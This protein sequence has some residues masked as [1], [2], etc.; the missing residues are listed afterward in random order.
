MTEAPLWLQL[1]VLATIVIAAGASFLFAAEFTR[2]RIQENEDRAYLA[3]KQQD[4]MIAAMT[5]N[6]RRQEETYRLI[7]KRR[8]AAEQTVA[9]VL[10]TLPETDAQYGVLGVRFRD[11]FWEGVREADEANIK[12]MGGRMNLRREV[13]MTPIPRNRALVVYQEKKY[14]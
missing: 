6:I 9:T 8:E 1:V 14:G 4:E 11:K 3:Q 10:P 12:A 5:A 13:D 7:L 2:S